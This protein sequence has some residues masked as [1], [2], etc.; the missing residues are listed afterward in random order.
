MHSNSLSAYK[1]ITGD[2][3][4]SS[5]LSMILE[6]YQDGRH[7]SDREVLQRLFP[8]S[9]DL[10]KVRPRVSEGIQAGLLEE[11]GSIRDGVT[12]KNVRLVRLKDRE[13]QTR[14]F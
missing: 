8:E 12:G 6:V 11:C 7:Y 13:P 3:S 10:N 5:R 9:D 2:G 14:M 4:R 1:T